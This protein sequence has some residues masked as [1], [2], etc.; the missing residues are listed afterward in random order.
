MDENVQLPPPQR[1]LSPMISVDFSHLPQPYFL[2]PPLWFMIIMSEDNTLK[3]KETSRPNA[4]EVSVWVKFIS[5]PGLILNTVVSTL[6]LVGL[7]N[8]W[9]IPGSFYD[10]INNARATTQIVVQIIASGLGAIHVQAIIQ[11]FNFASRLILTRRPTSLD[12][13]AL[14]NLLN[15]KSIDWSPV[16]IIC[17]V[18]ALAPQPLWVGARRP[19]AC[20]DIYESH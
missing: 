10:T 20:A 15:T 1:L 13:L 6:I 5:V 4:E 2:F 7:D 11:V 3:S 8:G 17:Y 12:R 16:V 9:T 19:N 18:V 14:W